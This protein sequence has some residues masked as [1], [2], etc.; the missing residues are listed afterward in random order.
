MQNYKGRRPEADGQKSGV[1]IALMY[2][3]VNDA[4]PPDG[5][6]VPVAR[7]REQ[8]GFLKQRCDVVS[9]EALLEGS[10]LT[11]HGSREK[12]KEKSCARRPRVVITFDDGYKDAY[13]NAYP[14]LKELGL[15]AAI[16]LITGMIGTNKKRDRYR[17]LPDPDMMSW[18]EVR[19]MAQQGMTFGAHTVTH[20]HLATL[21]YDEQKREVEQSFKDLAMSHELRA[22]SRLFC[23]PYGDYNT[24]TLRILNEIGVKAAFTV[25]PGV[26][27]EQKPLLELCRIGVD[28]RLSIDGF[29]NLLLAAGR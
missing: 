14:V 26:N 12:T 5:L 9:L 21:G 18:T 22:M 15:P 25:N 24:D 17:P 28:G 10:R 7:F 1:F 8:M 2:H 4:L 23:Y 20:P 3:R 11:A 27:D 19:E 29:E 6:V 13:G 16:F